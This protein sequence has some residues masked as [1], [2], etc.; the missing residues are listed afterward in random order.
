MTYSKLKDWVISNM[1]CEYCGRV[2]T[3]DY[4]CPNY[5]PPKAAHACSMCGEGIYEY[6]KYVDNENGELA[7]LDC[8]SQSDVYELTEWFG[9]EIKTM[10]GN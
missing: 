3:H 5:E 7:H 6:D 10:I 2:R 8:L 9:L 1:A 4:R